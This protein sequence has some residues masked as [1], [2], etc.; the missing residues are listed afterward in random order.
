MAA[1]AEEATGHQP[2]HHEKVRP[3]LPHGARTTAIVPLSNIA[4]PLPEIGPAYQGA[5]RRGSLLQSG[6]RSLVLRCGGALCC[7]RSAAL[8]TRYVWHDGDA[9][10]SCFPVGRAPAQ[11]GVAPCTGPRSRPIEAFVDEGA[12]NITISRLAKGQKLGSGLDIDASPRL[13]VVSWCPRTHEMHFRL[14]GAAAMPITARPPSW[15]GVYSYASPLRAL[16]LP[17]LPFPAA[18]LTHAPTHV[19]SGCALATPGSE[20]ARQN[21]DLR[22]GFTKRFDVWGR[23]TGSSQL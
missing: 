9:V 23:G 21:P 18:C 2:K 16:L 4:P 15:A 3:V 22:A 1:S 11:Q 14:Q 7:S 5:T 13:V 6:P 8:R 20:A 10:I 17:C 19:R 12:C